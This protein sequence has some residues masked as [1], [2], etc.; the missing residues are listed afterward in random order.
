MGESRQ[1]RATPCFDELPTPR[2]TGRRL[3]EDIAL[4]E[5][6]KYID[7]TFFFA[8]WELPGKYPAI[9][10]HPKKGDA[11]RELYDNANQLLDRIIGERLLR[12]NGVY[13]FWRARSEGDDIVLLDDD[14]RELTRFFMLRQ[15]RTGTRGACK[16]LADYVSPDGRDHL[17]GFAVTAGLGVTELVHKYEQDNDDYNAIMVKAL[18]DR[19]AE[20]LAE[21]LHVRA[22]RDWGYAGEE[23]LNNAGLIAEEY[24]GIRP[25]FGYPACPD[26]TELDKLFELLAAREIGMDLTETFAMTPAASVSGIYV[27]HPDAKY[28]N[29]GRIGRDQ[30]TDY[31][32]RKGATVQQVEKWLRANLG[33]DA[34]AS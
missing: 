1:R 29:V 9:L 7:W 15:Q 14:D 27:A 31:A 19:L 34:N 11:A 10:D 28:F 6:R 13:G 3:L 21:M 24:R 8:A 2:F 4:E 20:A 16:C 5:V 12:A 17:G 33:Y 26:H 30:V 25:A 23:D 32:K 18:A 22:R